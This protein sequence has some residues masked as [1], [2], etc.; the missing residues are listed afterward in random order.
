MSAA[1]VIVFGLL[2]GSF[3]NVCIYRLPRGMSV[4]RPGSRCPDC[5]HAIAAW[6]NIPVLSYVLLRGRCRQCRRGISL[7]YPAIELLTAGAFLWSFRH[8]GASP[9]FPRFAFFLTAILALIATDWDL[10]Q[11]PDEITLGGLVVGLGFAA[12]RSAISPSGAG[13]SLGEAALGAIVGGGI[14]WIVGEA[15]F[16]LRG[17]EGMGWG[18]VKMLALIGA[19]IGWQLTLLTL[20]MAAI[21]GSAAG[22][23]L[24]L[25]VFLRRSVR[26][27]RRHLS[28]PRAMARAQ[29][30]V[31]VFFAWRALPF[32][33]F[34]GAMAVVSWAW[35]GTIWAWY[36]TRWLR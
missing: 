24:A 13:L 25:A 23:V 36:A 28:W 33:V 5:Q 9:E 12:W 31:G 10:Q 7:R 3:L 29:Q 4:V 20:A 35:G 22:I 1:I 2:L 11:L 26:G 30:S 6:Q 17:R 32:G 14:L 21:V 16:R 34:L 18:D 8:Y 19:F 27:R 15:Y